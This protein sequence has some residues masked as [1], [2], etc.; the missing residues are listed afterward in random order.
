MGVLGE[1]NISEAYDMFA[2]NGQAWARSAL[3]DEGYSYDQI[4]ALL[5]TPEGHEAHENTPIYDAYYR[6][7]TQFNRK[8]LTAAANSI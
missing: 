3:H 4:G 7:R 5:D 2:A 6:L 8:V 1:P